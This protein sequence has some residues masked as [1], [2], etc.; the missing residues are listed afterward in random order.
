MSKFTAE[1]YARARQYARDYDAATLATMLVEIERRC[2][3][4][5]RNNETKRQKNKRQRRA[6]REMQARMSGGSNG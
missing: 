1:E 3:Q 6:N 4:L 2:E 5:R